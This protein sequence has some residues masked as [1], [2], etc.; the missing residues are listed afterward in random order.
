MSCKT[1]G[2]CCEIIPIVWTKDFKELSKNGQGPLIEFIKQFWKPLSYK[3][4]LI[5][6]KEFTEQLQKHNE[7]DKK[8]LKLFTCKKLNKKTRKCK[9][10]N[11][12]FDICGKYPYYEKTV[13]SKKEAMYWLP[14]CGYREEIEGNKGR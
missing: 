9:I 10:Q 13:V 1:C 2:N 6:N 7:E 12:K 8:Q 5:L 14:K 4:A 11:H 3:K